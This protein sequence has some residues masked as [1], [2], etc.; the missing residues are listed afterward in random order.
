MRSLS[1]LLLFG[2]ILFGCQNRNEQLYNEVMAIHDEV[3]PKMNDLYRAKASLQERLAKEELPDSQ[4]EEILSKIAQIDSASEGMMVWMREFEPV[5]DSEG[6][7]KARE[8]LEGEL[9]KVTK[10]KDDILNALEAVKE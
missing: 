3:M 4:R 2:L 7:D 8:Y 10:V 1:L 9:V 6:E 5:A